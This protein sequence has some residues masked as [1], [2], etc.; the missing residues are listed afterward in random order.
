MES[1]TKVYWDA[2]TKAAR[3]ATAHH[4]GPG[5]PVVFVDREGREHITVLTAGKVTDIRG[6]LIP[7]DRLFGATEGLRVRGS[8]AVEF[9]VVRAT[10]PQFAR[11]MQ[12]HATIIYPKDA[13]MLVAYGDVFPGATVVEG[14]YGSGALS[15]QI[16]RAIGPA[17]VGGRLVT[18]ELRVESKNRADKN[19]RAFMGQQPHHEV[20]L[21]DIY[22]G[23][24]ERGV[25][26]VILDVPEPW[27]VVDHAALALRPGGVFA[28]YVPTT[29]QLHRIVMALQASRRFLP[30]E[31]MELIER[32]WFVTAQSC[33][34]EQKI[35]GHTG[36]LCF[37]RTYG[38]AFVDCVD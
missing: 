24:D 18:Y 4:F 30:A 28:T 21:G 15:M 31:S 5:D 10:L 1:E 7:H 29:L 36:F 17:S 9:R 14:G 3:D 20:K 11:G 16:L 25:D 6:N 34:P 27:E 33:R 26:R 35:I 13:A 12:R 8:Q 32:P 37:A 23:I 2:D 22:Q 19:V 38:D